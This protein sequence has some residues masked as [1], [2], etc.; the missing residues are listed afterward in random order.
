MSARKIID[1]VADLWKHRNEA[2]HNR[3]NI[4]R[5]KDHN[6]LNNQIQTCMSQLPRS[7]RVFSAAEQRFFK[8]TNIARLKQCKIQQKQQWIDTTQSIINCFRE[9]LHS[10]PQARTMWRAMNLILPTQNH[11]QGNQ[12]EHTSQE[13]QKIEGSQ[14]NND[15]RDNSPEH[16]TTENENNNIHDYTDDSKD[17]DSNSTNSDKTQQR[18]DLY[19]QYNKNDKNDKNEPMG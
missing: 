10:N 4:V 12:Q 16:K 7:L 5:Q 19:D 9:N 1:I 18:N 6:R 14:E 17:E 11:N 3:D 13:N 8:R 15:G 2:L